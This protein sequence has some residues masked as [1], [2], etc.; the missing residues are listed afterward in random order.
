MQLSA[1]VSV[2]ALLVSLFT[3]WFSVL[4]R[5]KVCSTHPS[6]VAVRYD[7]VGRKVPLAKVFMRPLLYSTCKRGHVIEHLFLRLSEGD[8]RAEFS[9]WGYGE[10]NQ[11]VV[12]SGLSVPEAGVSTNHHFNPVERTAE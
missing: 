11:L 3:L 9:F 12:G 5:G 4:R 8:R 6:F 2:V 7:F 1:A 10:A